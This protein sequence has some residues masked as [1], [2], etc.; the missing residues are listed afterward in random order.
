[1]A[2]ANDQSLN[3]VSRLPAAS[4]ARYP[5]QGQYLELSGPKPRVARL[6]RAR[7]DSISPRRR[8]AEPSCLVRRCCG[9]GSSSIA[10]SPRAS[11]V[12]A[13]VATSRTAP[14]DHRRGGGCASGRLDRHTHTHTPPSAVRLQSALS[15]V[16]ES[17]DTA[18][19]TRLHGSERYMKWGNALKGLFPSHL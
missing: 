18:P 13:T 19:L 3:D 10:I 8:Q 6:Q 7:S 11:Y 9:L 1:M 14:C 17:V 16:A 12:G 5:L 15:T 2:G 4:R